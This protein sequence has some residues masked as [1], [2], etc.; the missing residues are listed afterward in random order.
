M[1][2]NEDSG[3]DVEK[4]GEEGLLILRVGKW[5]VRMARVVSDEKYETLGLEESPAWKDFKAVASAEKA[6]L[7]LEDA[8]YDSAEAE[9]PEDQVSFPCELCF[10]RVDLELGS[11]R[12]YIVEQRGRYHHDDKVLRGRQHQQGND[13]VGSYLPI[14]NWQ[15]FRP[16]C[17]S[18]E[19]AGVDT[20]AHIPKVCSLP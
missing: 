11:M 10:V 8:R 14:A 20:L 1:I 4:E 12:S 7:A 5:K 6:K 13:Q 9:H 18:L 16:R 2:R 17:P 3:H 15:R 19:H